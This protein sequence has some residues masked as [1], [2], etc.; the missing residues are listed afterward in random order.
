LAKA[1][2]GGVGGRLQQQ[3]TGHYYDKREGTKNKDGR[4]KHGWVPFGLGFAAGISNQVCIFV[5]VASRICAK[6]EAPGSSLTFCAHNVT[7]L[8]EYE[9]RTN[10]KILDK[11]VYGHCIYCLI[12]Y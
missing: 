12:S 6:K 5:C 7:Q 8:C 1:S 11:N 10:D 4:G 3:G 2:L 9:N